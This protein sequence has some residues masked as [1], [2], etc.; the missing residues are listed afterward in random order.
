[1]CVPLFGVTGQVRRGN[2]SSW[3]SSKRFHFCLLFAAL[4]WT[5][6]LSTMGALTDG[7]DQLNVCDSNRHTHQTLPDGY[8]AANYKSDDVSNVVGPYG[9]GSN[10]LVF[11]N[12]ISYGTKNLATAGAYYDQGQFEP[13]CSPVLHRNTHC[14]VGVLLV[15]VIGTC[16]KSI[17]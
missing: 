8:E 11:S 3:A 15:S 13:C 5:C 16:C 4:L 9:W 2:T 6:M 17:T 7:R 12:Y 10:C 14:M 1:M